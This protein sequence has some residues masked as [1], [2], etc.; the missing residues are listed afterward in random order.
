MRIDGKLLDTLITVFSLDVTNAKGANV[1]A[2]VSEE[3][4]KY[5]DFKSLSLSDK[6]LKI[7]ELCSIGPM[8]GEGYVGSNRSY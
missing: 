8:P 5:Y 2:T 3:Y 7:I 4:R 6:P 1:S